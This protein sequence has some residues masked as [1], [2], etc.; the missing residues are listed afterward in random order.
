MT[1]SIRFEFEVREKAEVCCTYMAYE[2]ERGDMH[3]HAIQN[4]MPTQV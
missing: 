2:G 3:R 1:I 4:S